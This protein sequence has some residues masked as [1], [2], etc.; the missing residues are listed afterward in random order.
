MWAGY[1]VKNERFW[2]RQFTYDICR[3][4]S[5]NDST[6]EGIRLEAARKALLST[7]AVSLALSVG[8]NWQCVEH[9]LGRLIILTDCTNGL[10]H[11]GLSTL[12]IY[13]IGQTSSRDFADPCRRIHVI[14]C[15]TA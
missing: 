11:D 8:E 2:A 12:S 3:H 14:E 4:R 6:Q 15:P 7:Q 9:H 1:M 10:I 13:T 5:S